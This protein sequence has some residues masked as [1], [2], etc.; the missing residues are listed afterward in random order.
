MTRLI[1][2]LLLALLGPFVLPFTYKR[3]KARV[4]VKAEQRNQIKGLRK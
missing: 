1:D 4:R 2:A 3:A